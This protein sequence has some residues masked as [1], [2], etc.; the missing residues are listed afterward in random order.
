[1]EIIRL[2]HPHS[3]KREALPPTAM[4]M[5]YFDG[6]HLG[7]QK[8]INEAKKTAEMNGWQ[9]AVMTFDPHPSVVLGKDV[10]HVE[11]I[12]PLP[13]KIDF[14]EKLGVDESQANIIYNVAIGILTTGVISKIKG[15]FKKKEDDSDSTSQKDDKKKDPPKKDSDE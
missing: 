6:V 15:I 7:H 10:K 8:V 13:D 12:T 4:A 2:K 5:G 3:Y 11:Y 1:M 14:I 9:T